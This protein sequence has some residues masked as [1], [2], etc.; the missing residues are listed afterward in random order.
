MIRIREVVRVW[1]LPF[2]VPEFADSD[3]WLVCE[4]ESYDAAYEWAADCDG[5]I[6]CAEFALSGFRFVDN[7]CI[8]REG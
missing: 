7:G 2:S 8:K 1:Y 5:R 4:F 3:G 6:D